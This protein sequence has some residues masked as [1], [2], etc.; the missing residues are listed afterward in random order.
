MRIELVIEL[1][2]SLSVF[3][4]VGKFEKTE[5]LIYKKLGTILGIVLFILLLVF[6]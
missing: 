6:K 5:K 2:L 4:L 1:L 3:I